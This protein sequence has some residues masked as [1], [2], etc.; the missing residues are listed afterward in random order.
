MQYCQDLDYAGYSDWRLASK[1]EWQGLTGGTC[2]YVCT[3]WD[4]PAGHPFS[5]VE[6]PGYWTSTPRTASSCP[7]PPQGDVWYVNTNTRYVSGVI[8][9]YGGLY[10]WCVRD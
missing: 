4:L 6:T 7:G 8:Q 3:D 5:N 1:A 10:V 9:T 2:D